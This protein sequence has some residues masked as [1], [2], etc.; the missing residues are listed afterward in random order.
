MPCKKTLDFLGIETLGEKTTRCQ[1]PT[2]N[3]HNIN[4]ARWLNL[5]K[6]IQQEDAAAVFSIFLILNR[7]P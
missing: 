2:E 1:T 4:L 5:V 3:L 6:A 7:I